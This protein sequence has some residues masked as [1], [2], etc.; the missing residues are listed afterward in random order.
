MA[1]ERDPCQVLGLPRSASLDDVKR[2]YRGLA[3]A[4]HP[5]AAGEAA[6]PRFLAIQ[7]AYEQIAGSRPDR[8]G[9]AR[10]PSRPSAAVSDRAGATHRAYG[11]RGR[12]P[13]PGAPPGGY[14]GGGWAAGTNGSA[15][16]GNAGARGGDAEAP[17][18]SKASGEAGTAGRGPSGRQA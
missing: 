13:R 5:D 11:A 15:S 2:A 18:G 4:N 17:R 1:V 16:S 8:P 3:K 7:A 12:R 9:Q 10:Q 6:L 14:P